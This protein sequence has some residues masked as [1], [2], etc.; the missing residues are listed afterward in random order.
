MHTSNWQAH[1]LPHSD[2]TPLADNMW[3][4]TGR[5]PRKAGQLPRN[6]TVY[7]MKDGGLL[8]HSGIAM[9]ES[10]TKAL[11]SLGPPQL[12]M[13]PNRMHR[14]DAG[15]YKERYPQLRVICPRAAQVYVEQKVAVDAVAEDE[16]PR[17]G[18]R[19]HVPAGLRPAE[20][21]LELDVGEHRALVFTDIL[22]N[23]KHAPGLDGIIL[24]LIRS[25]GYFG[26]T[27]VGRLLLLKDRAKFRGWL[28][29]LAEIPRLKAI[30]VG[31]GDPITAD[32]AN[33]LRSAAAR[34]S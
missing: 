21:C 20:V 14:L 16:L 30:C 4:V 33:R 7:R 34:L 31:H 27:P 22:F 10:A 24:K 5:L 25:S 12:L 9:N 15:V 1:V 2:L 8:I 19:C 17:H 6:M 28:E 29:Q 3:Q 23:L 26:M 32:C 11:E 13:V 18:I